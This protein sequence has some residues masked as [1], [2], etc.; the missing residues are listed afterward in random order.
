MTSSVYGGR[1]TRPVK[2]VE[3]E[4]QDLNQLEGYINDLL[5]ILRN[6]AYLIRRI[7]RSCQQYCFVHRNEKQPCGCQRVMEELEEYA[8]EAQNYQDRAK[9]LQT[10]VQ[11]VQSCVRCFSWPDRSTLY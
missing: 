5:M 10:E 11:S 7:K 6:K 8:A 9:V 3:S 2:F 1:D 4:R